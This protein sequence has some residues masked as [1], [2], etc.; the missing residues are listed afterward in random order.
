MERE[1]SLPLNGIGSG[2]RAA[3]SLAASARLAL[4]RWSRSRAALFG[5]IVV[6][7]FVLAAIFAPLLFTTDPLAINPIMRVRLPSAEAWFGTDAFGRDVYSR[8]LYGIR[9]SLIVG[10]SVAAI[11]LLIGLVLGLVAGYI[12]P[13]DAVIMRT[14]DGLMAIPGI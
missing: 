6:L 14:M 9:T 1:I 13:L 5:S 2:P 10:G 7:V 12:R 3:P 8:T 4:R 11:S